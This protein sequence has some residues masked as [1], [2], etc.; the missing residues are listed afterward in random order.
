MVSPE[1][2]DA[3]LAA[4]S[5]HV[6]ELQKS[7][8]Q[9][10]QQLGQVTNMVA[11]AQPPSSSLTSNTSQEDRL[12]KVEQQLMQVQ[13]NSATTGQE[14]LASTVMERAPTVV[15]KAK[16]GKH[17]TKHRTARHRSSK[18]ASQ[19][20]IRQH[21]KPSSSSSWVLRAATPDEAW[22]AKDA[23]SRDLRPV[24]VGDQLPG[25]GRVQAIR[26]NGD[27]WVVQGSEATLR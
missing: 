16:H 18:T 23:S 8:D 17:K 4:L 6:D 11:A 26:Q 7:L 19:H 15:P 22:V 13:H 14:M 5:T 12:N 9:A 20:S 27:S 10:T 21:D 24:H 2:T 1:S 3:R 25:I